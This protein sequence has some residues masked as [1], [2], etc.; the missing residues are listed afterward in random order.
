MRLT[1]R[2]R[3]AAAAALLAALASAAAA[4]DIAAAP[5][6]ADI[7]D[8]T[9][10]VAQ[11][12]L[13]LPPGHWVLVARTQV[14]TMGRKHASGTGIQ[15]WIAREDAGRLTALIWLSLPEQDFGNVHHQGN[16]RCPE[17][18]GIERADLS[19]NPNLPEC[20]GVYGHRDMTQAIAA[21][22]DA[23]LG[24]LVRAKVASDGPMVRFTYRQRTDYSYGGISLFLPTQHF[25]SED[26]SSAWARQLRDACRPLFEGRTSD[27]RLPALPVPAAAEDAAPSAPATARP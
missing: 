15:A 8:L 11:R 2:A 25:E 22:S 18:D 6:P 5:L 23:V 27:A 24:W 14:E 16:N 9:V 13:H 3:H 1:P 7:A 10:Q 20:L 12:R 17:E 4:T 21:R 26:A 19:D